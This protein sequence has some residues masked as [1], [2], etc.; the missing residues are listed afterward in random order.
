MRIRTPQVIAACGGVLAGVATASMVFATGIAVPWWV[1]VGGGL[2]VAMSVAV[3]RGHARVLML[4]VL[5]AGGVGVLRMVQA[6]QAAA[7][8]VLPSSSTTL[9]WEGRVR[10]VLI[11][12]E[13]QLRVRAD[14]VR[15]PSVETAH[16]QVVDF[17]LPPRYR[18]A[19]LPGDVMHVRCRF[20][21]ARTMRERAT[22][23]GTCAAD[24]RA[25][26]RIQ[27]ADRMTLARITAQWHATAADAIDRAVPEPS[28]GMLRSALLGDRRTIPPDLE[29]AFRAT[30]TM[31]VLVVSGWHMT[32]VAFA[33]RR[34][35]RLLRCPRGL[36]IGTAVL[37][38]LGML[39]VAGP[40]PSALRGAGMAMAV[41]A[42]ELLGRV[43]N[44]LRVLLL[45]ATAMVLARPTLLAFDV[46]FQLSVLATAG[47]VV[48]GHLGA[49]A[50]AMASWRS[51]VLDL[52][53]ASLAATVATAPLLA[54]TFGTFTPLGIL[55]NV[56]LVPVVP[57]LVLGG[58]LLVVVA[59][60]IPI[61]LPAVAWGV[62]VLARGFVAVIR[63]GAAMPGG[64]TSVTVDGWFV[65]AC[66][67]LFGIGVVQ[68]YRWRGISLWMPLRG[69]RMAHT[70]LQSSA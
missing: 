19:I 26:V 27:P 34:A 70:P 18:G 37:A 65:L 8:V 42:I 67:V 41:L 14:R 55:A 35:L 2:V 48:S 17:F 64:A 57:M 29:R 16:T 20:R 4:I 50:T 59:T 12:E 36:A 3:L 25:E 58:A 44:P 32:M 46:G 60:G 5:F 31:H 61:V 15:A 68:W 24:A 53:R 62:D 10:R 66:Y 47:L 40:D 49:P 22:H 69:D 23:A 43:G 7:R 9:M 6:T 1:G 28:A 52:L 11:A 21:P 56:L 13:T 38:V 45:T 51:E 54:W 39:S 30:G 33:V 63:F